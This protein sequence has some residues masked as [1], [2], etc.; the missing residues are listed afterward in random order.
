MLCALR[1]VLRHL[2]EEAQSICP[3]PC[4]FV[5]RQ[6]W[7]KYTAGYAYTQVDRHSLS[8]STHPV[9]TPLKLLYPPSLSI[10]AIP[11]FTPLTTPLHYPYPPIL[12]PSSPHYPS[13]HYTP[14][15]TP[16]P[17]STPLSIPSLPPSLSPPSLS[18]PT[19]SP[20]GHEGQG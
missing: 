6:L 16:P 15:A 19:L 13:T 2:D 1:W 5:I 3:C 10:L 12:L 20:P 17:L 14:L 8:L 9:N 7:S 4:T 11:P 18:P